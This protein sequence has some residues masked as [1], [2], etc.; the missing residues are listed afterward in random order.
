MSALYAWLK[1]V[2]NW[3]A[4]E[5]LDSPCRLTK[6]PATVSCGDW[7]TLALSVNRDGTYH[8]QHGKEWKHRVCLGS[9]VA[10][11][12]TGQTWRGAQAYAVQAV[13]LH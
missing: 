9:L 12:P 8:T 11:C 5:T 1:T 6:L 3:E 4:V 2:Q 13:G 10:P 7:Q